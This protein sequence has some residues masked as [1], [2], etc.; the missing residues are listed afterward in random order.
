[1]NRAFYKIDRLQINEMDAVGFEQLLGISA[2]DRPY[3]NLGILRFRPAG[4]RT[5]KLTLVVVQ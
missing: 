3:L 4:N 1:V 5:A 2:S